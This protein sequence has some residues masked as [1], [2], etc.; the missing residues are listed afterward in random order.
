METLKNFY[1]ILID[2][3]ST[4][5]INPTYGPRLSNKWLPVDIWVE[6]LKKSGLVDSSFLI[7]KYKFNKAMTSSKSEWREGMLKYDGTNDTGVFRVWFS[8][9]FYYYFTEKKMQVDYPDMDTAWKESVLTVARHVLVIPTTRSRPANA[10]PPDVRE[11]SEEGGTQARKRQR[12]EAATEAATEA[13]TYWKSPEAMK[14]FCDPTNDI[15]AKATLQLHTA[16]L[17][18]VNE[19]EEGW[20]SVVQGRDPNNL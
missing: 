7:D 16:K 19:T 3:V 14:L 13:T 10:N 18:K 5:R 8:K 11:H 2:A 20:R 4:L 9:Q 15:N 1:K 12:T 17:Q 6:A